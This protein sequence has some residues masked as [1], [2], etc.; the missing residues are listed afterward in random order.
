MA[1]LACV[2]IVELSPELW[3]ATYQAELH[4]STSMRG[5]GVGFGKTVEEALLNARLRFDGL[6]AHYVNTVEV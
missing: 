2:H 1:T 5:D 4:Y 3:Q 6:V